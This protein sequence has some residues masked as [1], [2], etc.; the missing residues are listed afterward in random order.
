[1]DNEIPQ[2]KMMFADNKKVSTF[3]FYLSYYRKRSSQQHKPS[4]LRPLRMQP[5]R[6]QPSR[7]Q[8]PRRQPPRRTGLRQLLLPP[9]RLSKLKRRPSKNKRK[10]MKLSVL[11]KKKSGN[12]LRPKRH[13]LLP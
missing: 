5:S 13:L 3:V 1:M 6:R 11:L 8:P 7:R 12:V 10:Q 4:A 2:S 9:S